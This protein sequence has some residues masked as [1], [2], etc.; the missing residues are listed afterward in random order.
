MLRL[1]KIENFFRNRNR[2]RDCNRFFCLILLERNWHK[3]SIR[4]RGYKNEV[5]PN[6]FSVLKS[7]DDEDVKLDY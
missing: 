6:S 3:S 5:S 2:K 7:K 4:E 1:G